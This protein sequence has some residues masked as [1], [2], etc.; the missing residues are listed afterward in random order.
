LKAKITRGNG[1]RGS[2]NYDFGPGK[3]KEDRADLISGNM[4]GKNP[5]ELAA[6]F[7]TCRQLR[8]NA[9]NP[10]WRTSLS[11]PAG[12]NLSKEKWNKIVEIY[13]SKMK[14]DAD[15]HQYCVVRHSDTKFDH[16]HLTVSR[17]GLDGK[18]WGGANDVKH[19]IAATQAIEQ[20]MGLQITKGPGHRARKRKSLSTGELK[21][22]VRTGKPAHKKVLQ[23]TI[24]AILEEK[25]DLDPFK[26]SLLKSGISV[27]LHEAKTG[28]VYGISFEIEGIAF[29]GSALGKSYS[30][31]ALQKRGLNPV[32][33]IPAVERLKARRKKDS[34]QDPGSVRSKKV[35]R[36]PDQKIT[37]K[38]RLRIKR[39]K[40][41]V[42]PM[43]R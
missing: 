37:A 10:C 33:N 11:C 5:K 27:K 28:R 19:A 25:S 12:E 3:N 16:I 13:L 39:E 43:E 1:F 18:L 42:R 8:S 32:K 17:I 24:D 41:R 22:Q 38:E 29:K 7:A 14:I 36:D 21:M 2:L 35:Q 26:K 23:A 20:E 34:E 31:A 15:N 4:T 9:K 6:E 30:W 40:E